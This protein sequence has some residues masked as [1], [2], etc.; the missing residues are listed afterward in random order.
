MA[1]DNPS[2]LREYLTI[3]EA[4]ALLEVSAS[5]LRNWDKQGKLR[6]HRHP[7]NDY[8]LYKRSDVLSLREKIRGEQ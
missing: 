1:T 4:A 6:P 5:T 3:A 7:I 2:D 8:R